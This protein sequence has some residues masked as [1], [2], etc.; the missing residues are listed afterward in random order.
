MQHNPALLSTGAVALSTSATVAALM[1]HL[2]RI[3]AVSKQAE[4][5]IYEDAL[6]MLEEGQADDES[7]VFVAARELIEKQLAM[8]EVVRGAAGQT[9]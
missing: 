6:L 3:G 7:G 8:D 4:H 1:A 5:E 9:E 2:G